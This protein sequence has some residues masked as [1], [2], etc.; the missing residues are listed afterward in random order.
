MP[1]GFDVIEEEG[2]PFWLFA[3]EGA[4]SMCDYSL[5]YVASRPA[6]IEDKLIVTTFENSITRGFAAVGEPTVAVCLLPGTEIAFEENVK[7]EP[8]SASAFCRTRRSRSAWHASG[9]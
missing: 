8:R 5:H 1:P 9:R 6:K 2:Q 3:A 4:P 7:Y